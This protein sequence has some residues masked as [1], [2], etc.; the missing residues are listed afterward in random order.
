[1][2]HRAYST[3]EI[4]SIDEDKRVITGIASTPTTD[5]MDDIVEPDGAIYKLPLPM[6]W[7]HDPRAPVGHVIAVKVA[8]TGI[9]VT[10]QFVKVD[11]PPSLKDDLDRA[12]AMVKA[13]LVRG[14]SI[15]FNSKESAEIEGSWGRRFIKWEWLELSPVTIPANGD[16]SIQSIKAIDHQVLAARGLQRKGILRLDGPRSP[17]SSKTNHAASRAALGQ[18][19]NGVLRLADPPG[20]S[21]TTKAQPA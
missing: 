20:A 16:C 6:L 9:A 8:K 17:L 21:G 4:K 1:M 18:T 13:G 12:W 10:C 15:G 2:D 7:M 5:R 14:F 3:F 11:E 19:R